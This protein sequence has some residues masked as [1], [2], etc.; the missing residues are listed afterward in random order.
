M[1]CFRGI[2]KNV[3]GSS[4]PEALHCGHSY[5]DASSCFAVTIMHIQQSH[6]Q[7]RLVS[8]MSLRSSGTPDN[9]INEISLRYAPPVI[10]SRYAEVITSGLHQQ[11]L[12]KI[13]ILCCSST[14]SSSEILALSC[15]FSCW[16]SLCL[17][18]CLNFPTEFSIFLTPLFLEVV[19]LA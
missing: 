16:I 6:S 7:N 18:I 19:E 9:K 10:S 3:P 12:S 1:N 2:S 14:A 4:Q 8:T 11:F 15:S 5:S 13:W 17:S